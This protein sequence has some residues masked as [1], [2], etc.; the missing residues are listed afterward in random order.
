MTT[1]PLKP[2]AR[3]LRTMRR[4]VL[5][6][7]VALLVPV[8][9]TG[10]PAS[11]ATSAAG[12]LAQPGAV[13][14]L[15]PSG[16]ITAASAELVR[17]VEEFN[18][19][20]AE[21]ARQAK[22]LV[23]EAERITKDA[24]ALRADTSSFNSK[25]ASVN[26]K[27]SDFNSRATALNGKISAHNSKPH[28]FRLP[29]QAAAA[30]AYEAEAS[31]LRAEQSQLRSTKSSLQNEQSQLREQGSKLRAK[32][33]QL[34]AASSAHDAKADA[35]RSKEQQLQSLGQQLLQQMAQAVQSLVDN[36]PNP[37]AMMD[38]GGDAAAPPQ[39]RDQSQSQEAGLADSPS[40]QPQAS[41][42][43]AYAQR[44]DTT[45]DMQPGTAYLTPEAVGRLPAAQAARLGSPSTTYDGLV[46]QPNGH[47]TALRVQT[48]GASETP[49]QKAFKT[50]LTG[51]GQLVAYKSGVKLI[52]DEFKP[53]PAP[54]SPAPGPGNPPPP[55]DGK[56]A[57]LTAKPAWARASGGGWIANTSQNV[58]LHNKTVD[59]GPS[60][61]RAATAEACLTKPLGP[62]NEAQGDIT[63]LE[64]ARAQ[65]PHGGLARC[66]LIANV[67]GGRGRYRPDRANLVPCWQRGMNT[68]GKSMRHYEIRVKKAVDTLPK[69]AAVHYVV[70]PFYRN[71]SSTIPEAV[72]I[73]ATV[74][75]PNGA[76]WPVFHEMS[77][78]NI[79]H[80]GGPNLG[81]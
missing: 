18:R 55:R 16:D 11:A 70:A 8:V 64:D 12:A 47:Y 28:T 23:A 45:V 57:C 44:N 72:S 40:R 7:L 3:R 77:L 20:E 67:L 50:A 29:A 71:A 34:A 52:I 59:P 46:R 76:S 14:P 62:G 33:S 5:L 63:G 78:L 31:R 51:R 25:T 32:K 65:A 22:A 61:S 74:Q 43:Q 21:I 39:Y 60:G 48:P 15:V 9:G 79:P 13:S 4:V 10:A 26:Q 24:A 37:A 73:S 36:P 2:T 80:D 38:Q 30:N 49:G 27:T 41:A 81:N 69:D 6:V 54:N 35:L 53:V 17:Q 66:H 68:K 75:L 58:A 19:Q 56:A 1:I 42:L